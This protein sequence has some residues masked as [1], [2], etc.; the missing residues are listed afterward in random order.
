MNRIP[1]IAAAATLLVALSGCSVT[2]LF[3]DTEQARFPNR[4]AL[5]KSAPLV[6]REAHWLPTDAFSIS[7]KDFVKKPGNIITFASAGGVTDPAC[8]SGALKGTSPVKAGWWPSDTPAK[9]LT[10]GDWKVFVLQ[11]Q[12]YAWTD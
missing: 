1:L 4:A 9:G 6:F 5:Q 10:C 11:G 8:T 7:T 2:G 3:A 12:W